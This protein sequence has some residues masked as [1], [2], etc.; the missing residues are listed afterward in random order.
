MLIINRLAAALNAMDDM[1]VSS[2][3]MLGSLYHC[4]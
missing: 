1:F 4:L 2:T 3:C